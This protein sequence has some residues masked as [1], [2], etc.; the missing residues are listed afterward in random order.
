MSILDFFKH[1][2]GDI[3]NLLKSLFKHTQKEF[4]NL[5]EAD[6]KGLINGSKLSELLKNAIGESEDV[7]LTSV[8][9]YLGVSKDVA[10]GVILAVGKDLGIDTDK[11]SDVQ[12]KLAEKAQEA[13][14]DNQWNSLWQ[15]VAQ[16]AAQWFT[17]G[18]FNW[19]SL[20]MGLL[21]FVY[22]TFVK[23]K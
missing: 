17:S 8:A 3:L 18:K 9:A 23:G 13:V 2:P 19:A 1:L 7:V 12:N 11:V 5:S 22:N 20:S 16:S 4:D 14:T 10:K 6:K 15:L 21:E